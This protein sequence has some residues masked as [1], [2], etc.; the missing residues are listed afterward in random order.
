MK[1]FFVCAGAMIVI[2]LFTY[3]SAGRKTAADST[4]S[5]AAPAKITYLANAKPIF[6]A[7]CSPCHFPEKQGNK[8]PLDSYAGASAQIDEVLRR[9]QLN[10][11]ERGFMPAR[12]PKLSDSTISVLKQWKADGLAEK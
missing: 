7:S 4:A 6:E 9:I 10:P 5:A 2:V 1:K 3:C 8:K 11:G 12:H